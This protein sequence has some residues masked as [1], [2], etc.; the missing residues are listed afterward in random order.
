M[1]S[2]FIKFEL[3]PVKANAR[4]DIMAPALGERHHR[5]T[6]KGSPGQIQN[7]ITCTAK[8]NGK[9]H[10]GVVPQHMS[11]G[12]AMTSSMFNVQQHALRASYT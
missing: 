1:F 8:C 2:N 12:S 10:V 6:A 5:T 9:M 3:S 11:I 4:G 7:K